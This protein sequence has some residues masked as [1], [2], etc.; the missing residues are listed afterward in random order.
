[1]F[2]VQ[3]MLQGLCDIYLFVQD[4]FCDISASNA[5]GKIH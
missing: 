5:L 3:G 4:Y 1:M 2:K